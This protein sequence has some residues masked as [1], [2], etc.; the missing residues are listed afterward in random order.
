MNSESISQ[1]IVRRASLGDE[2]GIALVHVKSWQEA[3][4]GLISQDF[5]DQLPSTLEKRTNMWKSALTNPERWI[6]VAENSGSIKGFACFQPP[7][8]RDKSGYGELSA[9]YL[10]ASEKGRGIGFSLLS[11]GF[12]KLKDQG[13]TKAYC[14][15]LEGNPTIKFY[16]RTGASFNGQTKDDEIGGKKVR[17]FAYDWNKLD[18]GD[19]NWKP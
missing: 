5:L 14:W 10:L 12:N 8:D 15:V 11:A 6:F 18:I 7:R 3:Y 17:E 1:T 19:C 2:A 4:N 16:E 9:I 13:F